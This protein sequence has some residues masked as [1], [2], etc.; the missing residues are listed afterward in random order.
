LNDALSKYLPNSV[1]APTRDGKEITLLHL[2]THTSGLP[3]DP[4]CKNFLC[5]NLWSSGKRYS[6]DRLYAFLSSYKLTRD[7]GAQYEYSNYGVALLGNA[8]A[9]RAGTDYEALVRTRILDPLKLDDTRITLT[10]G[11][12]ARLAKGYTEA[13]K[14]AVEQ[15]MGA[16]APAGAL[17]ST[18]YDL[19]KFL[20]A[21]M[22]L[23]PSPLLTAMQR[24]HQAQRDTDDGPDSEIGLGWQI[25]KRFDNE[26]VWHPG[27]IDG[28]RSFIGFNATTRRGVVLLWNASN[29][30]DDIGRH[31]LDSRYPLAKERQAITLDAKVL[32]AYAGEYQLEKP[33]IILKFTREGNRFFSQVPGQK[34]YEVFAESPTDFFLTATDSQ[35]SF[36]RDE[37]GKVTQ[38]VHHQNGLDYRGKKIR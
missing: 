27:S 22:G 2:A 29:E 16:L 20:A 38:L 30:V 36:V 8:L 4:E 13:L 32:D 5:T 26:I 14:P 11:M 21:N 31:L 1:R 24:A 18:T 25:L 10:P 7:P 35:D 12:R 34:K 37:S 33:S 9:V 3:R 23:S 28:Y 6:L 19:L 17:R 15:E